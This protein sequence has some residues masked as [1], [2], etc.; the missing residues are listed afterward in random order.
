MGDV[1]ECCQARAAF[2][3]SRVLGFEGARGKGLGV[4]KGLGL[5]ADVWRWLTGTAWVSL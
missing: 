4:F 2:Q 3:V 5:G 1:G